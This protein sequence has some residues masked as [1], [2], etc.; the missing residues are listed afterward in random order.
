MFLSTDRLHHCREAK[1]EF[2][3]KVAKTLKLSPD[4]TKV[5]WPQPTD[6]PEDPQNVSSNPGVRLEYLA[7]YYISGRTS[8]RTSSFSLSPWLLLF[9]IS[10]LAS[11]SRLTIIHADNTPYERFK[12]ICTGIASI[13]ALA[14]QYNTT[15]GVINNL[16]SKCV[17]RD[18]Y[19][20]ATLSLI[21][22]FICSWSIFLLGI[23]STSKIYYGANQT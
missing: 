3:E 9:P 1:I 5:L 2:G 6:D 7:E 15:T 18:S 12:C 14:K 4:G 19:M 17:I 20:F 11:A 23:R 21:L 16:T 8:A 22:P 10:I 13:F